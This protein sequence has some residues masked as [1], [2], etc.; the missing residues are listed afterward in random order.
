MNDATKKPGPD[1]LKAFLIE[2]SEPSWVDVARYL[3]AAG[4]DVTYWVAWSR[5]REGAEKTCPTVLFHD[6]IDAKRAIPLWQ[7]S[8]AERSL[9]TTAC[10]TLWEREAQTVYE[11]MI[12]FDHSR[13]LTYV[14]ASLHFYRL[15]LYWNVVIDRMRPDVVIFPTAPHVAY[16][17]VVY[18][19]CRHKGIQTLVFEQAWIFPPYSMS[20]RDFRE[21][22]L[23]LREQCARLMAG[24]RP[25]PLSPR[26][27]EIIDRL[28]GKYV[29]ARASSEIAFARTA[30]HDVDD[31]LFWAEELTWMEANV[32]IERR[33]FERKSAH[34]TANHQSNIRFWAKMGLIV[35]LASRICQANGV[36]SPPIP[37]EK[38]VNVSSLAKQRGVS[39]A[40]SFEGDMPNKHYLEQRVEHLRLA[41]DRFR[42][43]QRRCSTG[44]DNEQFIFLPLMFQPERTSCPQ[45]GI[46]SNQVIMVNLLSNLIPDEIWIYVKEH[47]TQLHPNVQSTQARAADFYEVLAG[48]KNVRLV[49]IEAD[50]FAMIDRCTAVAT[51]GGSGALEAVARGKPALVFGHAYYND[52]AG[53]YPITSESDLRQALEKIATHPKVAREDVEVFFHAIETSLFAGNAD[54]NLSNWSIEGN[55][56]NIAL[57]IARRVSQT[58]VALT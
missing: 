5:I 22:S 54:A 49:D 12:R 20:M 14:E 45:G 18:E 56:K 4:I 8:D 34:E 16:D 32:D 50:P 46:F 30:K 55:A 57:E 51:I 27:H 31:D 26:G 25:V 41:R 43:Y 10:R 15:L 35:G 44:L 21:G 13:D 39:L 9:F 33:W 29:Q 53:I 42:D 52:C 23:D 47:P 11:M 1:R 37:Y 6:T 58:A 17:Y 3:G 28:A 48:L 24:P 38:Q 19:L 2:C 7:F 40:A 36:A